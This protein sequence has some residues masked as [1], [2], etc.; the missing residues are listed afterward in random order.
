[1]A[2]LLLLL[3]ARAQTWPIQPAPF[4][5]W[6]GGAPWDPYNLAAQTAGDLAIDPSALASEE[7]S[8]GQRKEKN[9]RGRRE[10][11]RLA[12]EESEE[13]VVDHCCGTASGRAAGD[14]WMR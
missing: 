14:E 10:A 1:M 12:G 7:A 9:K 2:P 11:R 6:A 3:S 8:E 5:G 4:G 13:H